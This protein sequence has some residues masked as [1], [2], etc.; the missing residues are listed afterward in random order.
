MIE[1]GRY[2][3]QCLL[4]CKRRHFVFT[5]DGDCKAAVTPIGHSELLYI[6]RKQTTQN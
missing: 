5:A 1:K 2:R 4:S 6:Q 3:V